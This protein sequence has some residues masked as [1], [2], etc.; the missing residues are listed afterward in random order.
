MELAFRR[1]NPGPRGLSHQNR[2]AGGVE[3]IL[4]AFSHGGETISTPFET[5]RPNNPTVLFWMSC[6]ACE[7]GAGGLVVYLRRDSIGVT[8]WRVWRN[9]LG[10][11]PRPSSG[12]GGR[13]RD[14]LLQ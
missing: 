8:Y 2:G 10:N 9:G 4:V 3:M 1:R 6:G 5:R 11:C 7:A 13:R 14:N 12:G